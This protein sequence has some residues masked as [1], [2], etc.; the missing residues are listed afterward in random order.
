MINR[1]YDK[2]V[3]GVVTGTIVPIITFLILYVI[4]AE[5]SELGIISD[6]GF[7]P[8]F[9]IRTLSLVGIGANVIL[10]K[11]FQNRHAHQAVRGVIIPTFVFIIGWIVYFLNFLL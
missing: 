10:V 11:Y 3:Y 5:L 6:E 1:R 9:R 2:V 7:S 8:D 4:F